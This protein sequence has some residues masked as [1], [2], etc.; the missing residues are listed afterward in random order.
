M[1]AISHIATALIVKR[2]FPAA[3]LFGL[4]LA[5]EAVEFLWIGL[6]LVGLERTLMADDLRSVADIHLIH[7]PFSH[8]VLTSAAFA[9]LAGLFV[10]W[11]GGKHAHQI[12]V[13]ISICVGSHIVLDLIVHAPDI[14]LMPYFD[15]LKFGTGLYSGLPMVA[16]AVE[17]LWCVLCWRIYR[18]SIGLFLLILIIGLS[19]IPFYS[20]TINSGEEML[21]GQS[22]LFAII[23]LAQIIATSV[24]VWIFAKPKSETAT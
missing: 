20:V 7:M 6:N 3:P 17:L 21:A 19:S 18:G 12:A 11:W 5:T 24:L 2:R 8:S 10:L 9:V 16:F 14:P 13:A 15:Q 22:D 23:I 1:Q 4:I